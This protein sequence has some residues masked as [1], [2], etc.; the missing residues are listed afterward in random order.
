[1][2]S[3]GDKVIVSNWITTADLGLFSIAIA[4][5]K[6]TEAISGSVCWKLLLPVYS[7]LRQGPS[8]R[9]A[10]QAMKVELLLFVVCAPLIIGMA[11]FGTEL[12]NLL[13]DERYL[14]AGWMLQAMAVGAI[15]TAYNETQ[16]AM[17]I[18]HGH[19]YR[20][21]LFQAGRVCLLIIAMTVGGSM[22]GV[23]GL[24][25]SISVA[26]ALFYLV[27]LFNMPYYNVS[28]K[29]QLSSI[30]LL[31]TVVIVAWNVRGWPGIS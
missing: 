12:I 7:E 28:P 24:V 8:G 19:A 10:K 22:Y 4:L 3:Q 27:L 23:V 17:M 31:L 6:V 30:L 5:A 18:A 20:S 25:Y 26:P 14:G 9:L 2:G 29:V 11:L 16:V 1:M 13:Y 21:T 15:F